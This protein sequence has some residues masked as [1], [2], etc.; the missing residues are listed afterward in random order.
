M[1]GTQKSNH[2]G[3][4]GWR[5][6][7]WAGAKSRKGSF[8]CLFCFILDLNVRT[9]EKIKLKLDVMGLPWWY[10]GGESACQC[11]GHRFDS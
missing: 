3:F 7:D 5:M 11:K 6:G 2:R 4:C 1:E 8:T 9:T 10:S